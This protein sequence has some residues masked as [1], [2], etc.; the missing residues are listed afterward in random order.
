M[1]WRNRRISKTIDLPIPA[2]FL[3]ESHHNCPGSE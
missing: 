2:S 1:S 3:T